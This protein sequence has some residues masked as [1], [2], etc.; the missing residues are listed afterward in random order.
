LYRRH[1]SSVLGIARPGMDGGGPKEIWELTC[2][3]MPAEQPPI[4]C[5]LRGDN[6]QRL[7]LEP[8][9]RPF[10]DGQNGDGANGV[11]WVIA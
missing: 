8:S 6:I 9:A 10:A 1:V 5:I 7:Q 2:A 3:K 11:R 4:R